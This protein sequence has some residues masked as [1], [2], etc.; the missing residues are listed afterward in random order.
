MQDFKTQVV[1]AVLALTD[2]RLDE[3]GTALRLAEEAAKDDTKSSAGD[4]YET[5]REMMQQQIDNNRKL[6]FEAGRQRAF[7][8]QLPLAA[9]ATVSNGSLVRTSLGW[10]F[11]SISA[12]QVAAG[13]IPVTAISQAAPLGRLLMSQIPGKSVTFNGRTFLIEEIL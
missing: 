5:T 3:A 10:F 7:L 11:I 2:Q 8:L 13:G 4:K 6:L 9:T 1:E 12:G